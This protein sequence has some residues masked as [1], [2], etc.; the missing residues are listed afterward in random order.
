MEQPLWSGHRQNDLHICREQNT[1]ARM[2]IKLVVNAA[3]IFFSNIFEIS[4]LIVIQT[5]FD[6]QRRYGLYRT[7]APTEEDISYLLQIG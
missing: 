2:L 6:N 3:Q 1:M 4:S 5:K 7:I